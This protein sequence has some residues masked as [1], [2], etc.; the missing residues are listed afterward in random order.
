MRFDYIIV[1]AGSS[2][3]VLAEKLTA[4]GC[5]SVLLLEAGG[6]NNSPFIAMPRGFMKI[7]GKPE[8]FWNF[9]VASQPGRPE[10]EVWVYGKG[11]GG[12]SSVNGTWYLR[13][14]ANDYDSW[15]AMG[16]E[17]WNW[18]QIERCYKALE[19]YRYPHADPSR[20]Q[21]GPLEITE[22]LYRSPVIEA[23][24][25]AGEQMGLPRLADINTPRTEG[26]G[27]T[28]ATVDRR[29]RR[30][31]TRTTFLDRARKRSNL[32]ILTGTVVEKLLMRDKH[33][34]GVSCITP[35]GRTSFM[36]DKCVILSAGVIQSPTILQLSGIGPPDVL[37]RAGVSLVHELPAV[38]RNLAEHAMFSLSFRL[39]NDPGVNR[40]FR[41]WRLGGHV[42]NYYL[43]R[44]GFMAFTSV[45][46][47][48]LI[49]AGGDKTW[50]DVQI[51]IAPFSMRSSAERKADPGRGLLER[52]PGITFNGFYLRPKSRATVSIHTSDSAVPPIIEANWWK[53]TA[54]RDAAVNMVRLVRRFA[55]QPALA[56]FIGDE[57]VPGSD[58]Q[59]DEQIAQALLWM[60]SPGLHGTGT[61]RMGRDNNSVVDERLRVHGISGL[62]VVDCSVMPTPM[63]GNTNGPAMV[64]AQRASELILEDDSER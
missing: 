30:A 49:A 57:T 4:D 1:G 58:A 17:G 13:G 15:G 63:S 23:I 62:R 44:K 56:K 53:E 36:A 29:G 24:L 59:S 11:L 9:P 33:A 16:L 12:S 20:G 28:Q 31:S 54:D 39:R 7:W 26:I 3:A 22:S 43:R 55:A 60:I 21:D 45:E 41:A 46:V 25:K 2:G 10:G 38:G 18:Q 40:E 42:L 6:E 52:E 32:T 34:V 8:Y 61:C 14:M 19:S 64:L 51:G 50:P 47:T 5:S 27:Y 35:A 48:A 37:H